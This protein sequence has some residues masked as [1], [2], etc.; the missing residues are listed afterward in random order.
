MGINE[1]V[2]KAVSAHT[3]WNARLQRAAKSGHSEFQPA[4]VARDDL[5]G[6][7]KWLHD[8]AL[9]AEMRTSEGYRSVVRLHAEFHGSAA[10]ALAKAIAGDKTAAADGSFGAAAKRLYAALFAWQR[11]AAAECGTGRWLLRSW[12]RVQRGRV[13]FRIWAV[14]GLPSLVAWLCLIYLDLDHMRHIAAVEKVDPTAASAAWT[15]FLLVN[16]SFALA[17]VIGTAG[18]AYLVRG[19]TGP[20]LHLVA[21]ARRIAEGELET[22]L[23]GLERADEVGDMARAV[24]VFQQ[25]SIAVERIAAEREQQ[26]ARN[27]NER[28]T[29]LSSMADNIESQTSTVVG[30]VAGESIQVHQT[31]KL[32]AS[33]AQRMEN[34]SQLV[35]AAAAQSLSNA[36]SLAGTAAQLSASIREIASQVE[37]SRNVVVEAVAAAGNASA[38]VGSLGEAMVSIDQV[39]QLIA[40]IAAQTNLLALNATIEA[41]RAGDAGKGFAVVANE[42]KLL[43][44]QTARQTEEI[45]GRIATLKEMAGRVTA[46]IEG[47]VASV[48]SVET[49]A[50][51]VAAAVEE[52]DAA[53][54]EISRTVQQS[55]QAAEQV[56]ERIADVAREAADTGKQAG[57]VEVMLD[58]MADQL[59]DLGHLLNRVVRTATPEVD[60]RAF[61]RQAIKVKARIS[62]AQGTWDGDLRD[63]AA[64]GACVEGTVAMRAGEE[65]R[66]QIGGLDL[67]AV[68]VEIGEGCCRLSI[69]ASA[70]PALEEWIARQSGR[71]VA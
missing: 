63:L 12:C 17:A 16:G 41:A 49:I 7:G 11:S 61:P 64:G 70:K 1:E 47:T 28:R 48:Q 20:L 43:A 60:R 3:L 50:E 15:E 29:A 71:A 45:T 46:A 40:D 10:E 6:F 13:A 62:G 57:Q 53:T 52:Q 24:L 26:R 66:L 55:A 42:V 51:S 36:Q 67:P 2:A 8:P 54:A 32:M 4:D 9:P 14:A 21:A 18:V 33:A 56:T 35:A 27:E 30:R 31:A 69:S 22:Q 68:V 23:P 58:S 38:T 65:A 34:N 25:Q 19:I 5:C 39:V 59:S 37:R 44:T